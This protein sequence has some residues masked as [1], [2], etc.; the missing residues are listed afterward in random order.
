MLSANV[1]F[2]ALSEL[3]SPPACNH[4]IEGELH[5][6]T[7]ECPAA[8]RRG[9]SQ[10]QAFR[11]SERACWAPA[12]RLALYGLGAAPWA[13]GRGWH[14]HDL[15]QLRNGSEHDGA[16][17]HR[18]RFRKGRS[19]HQGQCRQPARRQLFRSADGGLDLPFGARYRGHV[20]RRLGP[21]ICAS[22]G[23]SAAASARR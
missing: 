6:T 14:D 19:R 12:W 20:D 13:R 23:R 10:R 8:T 16:Q 7:S 3:A 1:D 15:A 11:G 18:C 2:R 9:T 4:W 17:C 5:V 21:E 22:P